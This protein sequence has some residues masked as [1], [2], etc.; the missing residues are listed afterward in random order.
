[1]SDAFIHKIELT[2]QEDHTKMLI[3]THLSQMG[4]EPR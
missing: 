4:I 1:M 3:E 2:D